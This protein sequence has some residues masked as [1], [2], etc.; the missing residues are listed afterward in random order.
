MASIFT[1]HLFSGYHFTTPVRTVR[2]K[3]P[4]FGRVSLQT[5]QQVA[6][7]ENIR[8]GKKKISVIKKP[9]KTEKGPPSVNQLTKLGGGLG[10]GALSQVQ[11]PVLSL[12]L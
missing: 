5:T 6:L 11:S 2:W 1:A 8:F 3:P 7:S 10:R 9:I 4:A 12:T